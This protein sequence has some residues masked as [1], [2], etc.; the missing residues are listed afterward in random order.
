[1]CLFSPGSS[2]YWAVYLLS[3]C[4]SY[5]NFKSER[6]ALKYARCLLPT[7]K[8]SKSR[9][10]PPAEID[11]LRFICSSSESKKMI[12]LH[13]A[14]HNLHT[15]TCHARNL[16]P[17]GFTLSLRIIHLKYFSPPVDVRLERG[18]VCACDCT[19]VCIFARLQKALI[20]SAVVKEEV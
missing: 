20:D 2:K 7:L 18:E 14:N 9:V 8:Y 6:L 1:M 19:S 17:R 5:M 12:H 15:R 11:I 10:S 13:A 3:S 16:P 4:P